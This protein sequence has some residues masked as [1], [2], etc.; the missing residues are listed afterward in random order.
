VLLT[1]QVADLY[2]AWRTTELRIAIAHENAARQKRSFEITERIYTSGQG[3][4]L[5]LQQAKTQYLATLAT[6][7]EQEAT[8]VQIR[9]ALAA[10]LRAAA[11]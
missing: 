5:D 10:L 3:S 11:R 1:A 6:I 9:N 2:F 8:L 4:E 7:P